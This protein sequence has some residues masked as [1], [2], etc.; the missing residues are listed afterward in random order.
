MYVSPSSWILVANW[1]W[2]LFMI[3]EYLEY[4]EYLDCTEV[5]TLHLWPHPRH[6]C[7]I[8]LSIVVVS[9]VVHSSTQPQ[10]L[11]RLRWGRWGRWGDA[12]I[13]LVITII[14]VRGDGRLGHWGGAL[15]LKIRSSFELCQI[16]CN[17]TLKV[18]ATFLSCIISESY[19]ADCPGV[20]VCVCRYSVFVWC[21][22]S[23]W[24]ND[25]CQLERSLSGPC[26]SLWDGDL[27]LSLTLVICQLPSHLH[28]NE[29][30][31]VTWWR[32]LII[33]WDRG[34]EY[35]NANMDI[36]STQYD[37]PDLHCLLYI[38]TQYIYISYQA[39]SWQV[40]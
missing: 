15:A 24:I 2:L 32:D 11:W 10:P 40:V 14:I 6:H 5:W 34:W 13:F 27:R 16:N 1:F 20:I 33:M 9:V 22:M 18:P 17:K 7:S 4:L 21:V 28:F 12:V 31:M 37:L 19:T 23:W 35:Y 30:F 29:L 38:S 26:L 8:Q 39:V 25:K 3:L 36:F